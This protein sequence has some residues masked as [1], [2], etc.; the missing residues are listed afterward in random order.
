M[1]GL[2]VCLTPDLIEL[3]DV[4]G[5]IVVVVDILR[6][7]SSITTGL[8]H[9][10]NS[11]RPVAT[12]SECKDLQNQGYIAAAER[13]GMMVEGFDLGNSP[14]G[15]M[16]EQLEGADVAMTTTNGTLAITKSL[17]AKQIIIGSFLN[18]NAVVNY[19]KIQPLD[20]LIHCAGWKGRI[21]LE[22]SLFAGAIADA[23]KNSCEFSSD[24]VAVSQS[25]FLQSSGKFLE[26]MENSS[27]VKRLKRLGLE[28]DIEFCFQLNKYNILP[29]FKGDHIV[30]MTLEDML[31][32]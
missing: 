22:D 6:A 17:G 31:S 32:R 9:K 12:L 8:A 21:N 2:E 10:V 1:K 20:I 13:G 26:F 11:I 3:Y 7:T 29:V 24:A 25:L 18:F 15:F 19:L 5:K 14:F 28:K 30:K 27:H 23:L 4:R 16:I